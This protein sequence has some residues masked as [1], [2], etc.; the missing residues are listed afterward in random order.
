MADVLQVNFE[1]QETSRKPLETIQSVLD[2]GGVIAFPTDTFYGL[3]ADPFNAEAV[4]KIFRI[5]QRPADK[6]LLVLIHSPDQVD[7]LTD[8]ITP[9]AKL[10]M[11]LFWPGSLTLLFKAAPGLP[12]ELTAGTGKVGI[13]LPAHLFTLQLL[14]GLDCPLTAPSANISGAREPVTAG[15]V[16]S[17][18][19]LDVIVD[20]GP[21]PGGKPSTILDAT[22]N[23]PTLVREGAVS[24][25]DLQ[26][27]LP[28]LPE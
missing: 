24:R 18:G 16:V 26:M 23:P 27:V 15:E 20:G 4:S 9:L 1:S 5:K 14:E 12:R 8:Q 6:P 7:R 3:G 10:L 2:S 17:A 22:T 21:A 11:R 13:R 25:K 28:N 19:A